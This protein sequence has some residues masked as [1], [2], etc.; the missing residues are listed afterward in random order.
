MA[1]SGKGSQCGISENRLHHIVLLLVSVESTSV[2]NL[3]KT[4]KE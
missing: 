2:N 4:E 1:L 3:V